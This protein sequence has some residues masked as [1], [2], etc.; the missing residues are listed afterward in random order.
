MPDVQRRI[1]VIA[2]A[3]SQAEVVAM[4]L[5]QH[6]DHISGELNPAFILAAV[7]VL[8]AAQKQQVKESGHTSTERLNVK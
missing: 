7:A 2:K 6:K 1:V 3:I 8:R 4:K 5:V